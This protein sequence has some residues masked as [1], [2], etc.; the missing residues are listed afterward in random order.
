M[1]NK[2]KGVANVCSPSLSGY[3]QSCFLVFVAALLLGCGG[4]GDSSEADTRY[5][6]S[7]QVQ[8][9]LF[10][11]L[12][13]KAIPLDK[14]S[15]EIDTSRPVVTSQSNNSDYS[16]KLDSPGPYKLEAKADYQRGD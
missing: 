15:G 10:T 16:L 13:V 11:R 14:D 6:I 9:G 5:T 2:L 1:N 4:G 12:E 8:K 3:I 7:G